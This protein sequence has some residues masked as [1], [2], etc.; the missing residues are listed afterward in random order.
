MT[1]SC[2]LSLVVNCTVLEIL[3]Y[4]YLRYSKQDSKEPTASLMGSAVGTPV[5]IGFTHLLSVLRSVFSNAGMCMVRLEIHVDQK[6]SRITSRAGHI[7]VCR[8]SEKREE[9]VCIVAV[10][11]NDQQPLSNR[12]IRVVTEIA[13]ICSPTRVNLIRFQQ[14]R[15]S[16]GKYSNLSNSC[17][18]S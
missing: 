7:P 13:G 5:Q 12:G 9:N 11:Y 17:F 10:K 16:R 15:R 3:V 14:S 18:E 2:V 6:L 4:L 1:G 8:G